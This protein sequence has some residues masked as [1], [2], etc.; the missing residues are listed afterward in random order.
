MSPQ[1]SPQETGENVPRRPLRPRFHQRPTDHS[2]RRRARTS[3]L[4]WD[5]DC[6]T[7]IR[8]FDPRRNSPDWTD[9]IRPTECAVLHGTLASNP[10]PAGSIQFLEVLNGSRWRRL[11]SR[12]SE[13]G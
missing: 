5:V 9:L 1:H 8:L 4:S 10:A 12:Y 13:R 2:H 3:A 6:G 11:S 7:E